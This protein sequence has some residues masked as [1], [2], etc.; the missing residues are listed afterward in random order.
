[1]RPR[2]PETL[3]YEQTSSTHEG[4]VLHDGDGADFRNQYRSENLLSLDE[5][6]RSAEDAASRPRPERPLTPIE[7]K[8][9]RIGHVTMTTTMLRA[10]AV[11]PTAVQTHETATQ[12]EYDLAG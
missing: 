2:N 11:E 3:Q 1:M 4:A 9:Y 6:R 12:A 5:A 7:E 8:G 10:Q